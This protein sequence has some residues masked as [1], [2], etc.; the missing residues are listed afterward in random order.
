MTRVPFHRGLVRFYPGEESAEDSESE[1]DD[2][3][4]GLRP[5]APIEDGEETREAPIEDPEAIEAPEAPIE[6][7]ELP[8]EAPEEPEDG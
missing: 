3:E 6:P 8:V 7:P 2:A 1:V 5:E 4:V